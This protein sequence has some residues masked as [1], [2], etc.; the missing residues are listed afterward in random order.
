MTQPT[1]AM[2]RAMAEAEVGDDVYGED[3]TVNALE[4]R[5]AALFEREAALFVPSGTW[6][7]RSRSGSTS[8]LARTSCARSGPT[9]ISSSSDDGRLQGALARPSGR[10]AESWT[11][12]AYARTSTRRWRARDAR[13]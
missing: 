12:R 7:T 3:P 10:R 9:S 6:P 2:R 5:A 11:G 4:H 13:P 1:P 8:S